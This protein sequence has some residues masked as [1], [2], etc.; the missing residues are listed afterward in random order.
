MDE[1]LVDSDLDEWLDRQL[2]GEREEKVIFGGLI[3]I[4]REILVLVEGW[5]D[6]FLLGLISYVVGEVLG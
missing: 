1:C 2:L 3:E 6:G 5:L 4:H